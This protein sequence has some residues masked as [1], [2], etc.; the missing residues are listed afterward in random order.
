MT[1]APP[2]VATVNTGDVFTEALWNG[3]P[4][5]IDQWMGGVPQAV[6]AQTVAQSIP[7][8]A[9]TP[10]AFDHTVRDNYAGFTS[11]TSFYPAAAGLYLVQA[12]ANLAWT[13]AAGKAVGAYLIASGTTTWAA[14]EVPATSAQA[15]FQISLAALIPM[16]TTDY[17]QLRL[18]QNSG[19]AQPTGL[20]DC[21][22]RISARWIAL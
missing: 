6:M 14:T 17:L 18:F 20:T 15:R 1:V 22:C 8:N 9:A 2:T 10:V 5:A 11:G 4:Q 13:G 19:T 21:A 16:A 12:T 7:N 3:G